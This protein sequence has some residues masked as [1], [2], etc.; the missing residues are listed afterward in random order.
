MFLAHLGYILKTAAMVTLEFAPSLRR[1]V[2]CAPQQLEPGRLR[3]VLDA[4]LLAAPGL[5]HY[6][7]DDQRAVRKHVAIFINK[8]MVQDR[9][10]LNHAVVD[11]D[12]VLV[13]QALTGG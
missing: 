2:E 8:T 6:V 12:Q 7:L 5:T 10:V 9:V 13:V 1:H 4:A 3:E 11:G